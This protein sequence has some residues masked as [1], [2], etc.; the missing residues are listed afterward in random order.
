MGLVFELLDVLMTNIQ[1]SKREFE[2]F[3]FRVLTWKFIID[4][5]MK[6]HA[7]VIK[8]YLVRLVCTLFSL[9]VDM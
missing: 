1:P 7:I 2:L 4:Y 5:K 8:S 6:C 3:F 9:F